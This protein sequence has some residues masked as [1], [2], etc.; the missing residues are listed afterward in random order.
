MENPTSR[1]IDCFDLNSSQA[2]WR[3]PQVWRIKLAVLTNP[4]RL[5]T[6]GR[7]RKDSLVITWL[8]LG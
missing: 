1:A 6:I 8:E 7:I 3:S 5:E 4:N 2:V